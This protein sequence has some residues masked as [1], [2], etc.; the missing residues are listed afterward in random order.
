MSPLVSVGVPVRNGER[1]LARQL[2]SLLAQDFDDL[3]IVISDNASTD[4]TEEICRRYAA[5]DP[6]IRYHRSAEDR[7][8]AWNHNRTFELARAP[9]FKWAA[10]DD[11]HEPTYVSRTVSVL[12]ADPSV[13]CCQAAS[14]VIDE[15]GHE[16]EHWPARELTASTAPHVRLNEML[17]PHPVDMMYGLMRADVLARTRLH[18]PFPES[19]H[20]LLAELALLGRLVEVPEPLFRRRR[21]AENSPDALPNVRTRWRYF[22]GS[23]AA[24]RTIPGWPLTRE[25]VRIVARSETRGLERLLCWRAVA[26]WML[27]KPPRM[28]VRTLERALTAA[29]RE[30]AAAH[31][32]RPRQLVSVLLSRNPA[33]SAE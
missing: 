22:A 26:M 25:M 17:R 24:R 1:F 27:R 23:Q 20:A 10:Y 33:P 3:E 16:H 4:A 8:L 11:E 19:D 14:V 28:A 13:V 21:H 2:E 6:R 7:G 9:Y 18:Q 29:G 31:V 30:D 5:R 32:R 15:E 12:E